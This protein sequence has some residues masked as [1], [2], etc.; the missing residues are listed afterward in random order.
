MSEHSVRVGLIGGG[1]WGR[2]L[3]RNFHA[4]GAL[5][6][7]CDADPAQVQMIQ[8]AYPGVACHADW[9]SLITSGS[10]DAVA[11]ATPPD[12]HF[13]IAQA[14]LQAGLDVFVEKPICHSLAEAKAL[15]T[16]ADDGKRVVMAGHLLQYHAV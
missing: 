10:V 15:T 14:A 9:Q 2:N 5:R 12:T 4:L 1:Y 13:A 7:F 6:A 11:I 16:L 3:A 8:E